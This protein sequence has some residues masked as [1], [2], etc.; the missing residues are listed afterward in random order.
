MKSAVPKVALLV[1][2]LAAAGVGVAVVAAKP[3]AVDA[4]PTYCSAPGSQATEARAFTIKGYLDPED[5]SKA[6]QQ[7]IDAA[8]QDGGGIVE[9]PQGTLVL[10]G[11]LILKSNVAL[12]GTGAA[13]VLKAGPGFLDTKGP[14]GGHPLI[15]TNGAQNV[16]IS[17]LTADQS[18]DELNGNATGRLTE[19]L[20]DVR[21][22]TNALVEDVRTRNPFT[23]SIAVVGSSNFCVRNNDTLVTSSGKYDQLDGIHITDSHGGMVEG[24]TVDQRQGDDGD[25]GLVAQTIGSPVYDVIYRNNKVRGGSHGSAMQLAVGTH[26]IYNIAVEDNRFWGSPNGVKIGYYDGTAAVH[27]VVVKNNSF[28]DTPGPWLNF[29][30]ELKNITVTDNV[31]CQSGAMTLGDAPG[32]VVSNNRDGC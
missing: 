32:N 11:P 30:G 18:G 4:N 1:V 19:Y 3:G 16:T 27:D 8:S 9:L 10:G 20:I 6:L 23:Y 17:H 2:A 24:N 13:T 15:T 22:S 12:K 26:E 14:F 29:Q 21:H 7:L 31:I 28:T 5:T 25:D